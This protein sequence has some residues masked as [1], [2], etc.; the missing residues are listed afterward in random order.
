M[1]GT[2]VDLPGLSPAS[3]AVSG[4]RRVAA[5]LVSLFLPAGGHFVLG[6]WRRGGAL[7]AGIVLCVLSVPLTRVGL[8]AGLALWI[9]VCVDVFFVRPGR[10]PGGGRLAVALVFWLIVLLGLRSLTRTYYLEAFKIPA[11]SMEP[12]LSA[13]DHLFV[14]K[15]RRGAER[16]QLVAFRHPNGSG[17]IYLSRVI[18][19]AGDRIELRGG[20]LFLNGAEVER[21]A[22]RACS[23]LAVRPELPWVERQVQCAE[24]TLGETRHGMVALPA[25]RDF[26]EERGDPYVVPPDAVFVLADNRSNGSDSRFYGPVPLDHII[27][28]PS[29]IW[30]SAAD[31]VRWGRIGDRIR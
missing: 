8:L 26:P 22:L 18:G 17:I 9:A 19:L 29:F 16:G 7:F 27:G 21:T 1:D 23:Y 2:Q 3:T 14:E 25:P 10:I 11:E 13:G 24:E 31:K 6:R 20:A 30:W 28:R 15:F 5:F 4:A 12:T